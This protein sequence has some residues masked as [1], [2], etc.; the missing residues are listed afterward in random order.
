MFIYYTFVAT[1]KC[2]IS[3]IEEFK[4][5]I[6]IGLLTTILVYIRISFTPDKDI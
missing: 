4:I 1:D 6:I 2:I 5:S 3:L